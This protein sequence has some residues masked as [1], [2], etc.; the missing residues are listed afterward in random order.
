MIKIKQK[1]TL[2]VPANQA[3]AKAPLG[4]TL[5]QYGIPIA[6]FCKKFN[7]LSATYKDGTLI[8]VHA[9]LFEDGTY[10]MNLHTPDISFFLKKS[11]SVESATGTTGKYKFIENKKALNVISAQAIYEICKIKYKEKNDT[12]IKNN[13]KKIIHSAKSMGIIVIPSNVITE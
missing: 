9:T 6:D 10:S 8:K 5:G 12:Y 2:K 7:E 4:P 11:I 13:F 3:T 1:I